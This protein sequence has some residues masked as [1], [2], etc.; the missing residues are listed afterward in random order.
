[1]KDKIGK[2]NT[3]VIIGILIAIAVITAIAAVILLDITG[4]QGSGLGKEYVYEMLTYLLH[5][6]RLHR[7]N[8]P[9]DPGWD[10]ATGG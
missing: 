4:E 8:R 7:E 9:K 1:M 5:A 10:C 3:G 6:D 2:I